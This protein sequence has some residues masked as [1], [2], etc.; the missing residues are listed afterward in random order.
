MLVALYILFIWNGPSLIA[1]LLV[2][3]N[4]RKD[5]GC[6]R[7]NFLISILPTLINILLIFSL[8]VHMNYSIDGSPKVIGNA[9]FSQLLNV[10]AKITTMY[11]Y[12][13]FMLSTFLVPFLILL[14]LVLKILKSYS[15]LISIYNL[16]F[17][18]SLLLMI[19]LPSDFLNWW[20]D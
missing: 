12:I 20:W 13:L 18:I 4:A 6:S 15:V 16:S 14:S 11:W 19:L 2:L 9:G 17:L 8:V 5:L 10:H 3:Y 7:R 1:S